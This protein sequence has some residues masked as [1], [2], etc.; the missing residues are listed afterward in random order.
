MH[1]EVSEV[2]TE[3]NRFRAVIDVYSWEIDKLL[4][5]WVELHT[6]EGIGVG[7]HRGHEDFAIVVIANRGRF[8]HL[9]EALVTFELV[10]S[11]PV[12]M[13]IVSN[14]LLSIE[15]CLFLQ[16]SKHFGGICRDRIFQ[17]IVIIIRVKSVLREYFKA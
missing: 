6:V 8:K 10:R 13:M 17:W 2:A 9:F 5:L 3:L 15:Q 16:R 7:F 11:D 1:K 4:L 12:M 14:I